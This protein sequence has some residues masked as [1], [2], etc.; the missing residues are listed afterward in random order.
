MPCKTHERAGATK[1]RTHSKTP[2][3]PTKGIDE[4][5]TKIRLS[6][7]NELIHRSGIKP[8]GYDLQS[9]AITKVGNLSESTIK[10]V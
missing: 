7:V 10:D 5:E 6:R 2:N 1:F 9:C 4:I 3:C 8:D